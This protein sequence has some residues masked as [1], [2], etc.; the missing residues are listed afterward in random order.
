MSPQ[1]TDCPEEL[2]L[3]GR[4]AGERLAH[5]G[6]GS[7]REAEDLAMAA[8]SGTWSRLNNN[9]TGQLSH[10]ISNFFVENLFLRS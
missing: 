3:I 1:A 2:N 9:G 7:G 6:N 8:R 5:W 10:R 4:K